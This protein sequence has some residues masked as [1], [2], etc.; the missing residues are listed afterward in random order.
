LVVLAGRP[1][2]LAWRAAG[3]AAVLVVMAAGAVIDSLHVAPAVYA[4]YERMYAAALVAVA[5]G[6]LATFARDRRR[7]AALACAVALLGAA[8]AVRSWRVMMQ[9]PTDSL[10]QLRA[11][12]WR[13]RLPEGSRVMWLQH[14]TSKV[15]ALPLYGP[16]GP[17]RINVALLN[18]Q[19]P[20]SEV[21]VGDDVGYY[22][23]SSLCSTLSERAWCEAVERRMTLVPVQ[24]F[25]LPRVQS[26]TWQDFE[27]GPVRVGLYRVSP[28]P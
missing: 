22:Y 28:R 6:V 10:E 26:A 19:R 9:L 7:T 24:V 25:A 16:V 5:A 13:Q 8:H 27:P 20:A 12:S 18:S 1:A 2:R 15:L 3:G 21:S 23:R 17:N 4:G 11:I 14:T